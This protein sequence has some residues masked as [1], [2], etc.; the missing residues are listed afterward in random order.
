MTQLDD[1]RS[2]RSRRPLLAA[3]RDLIV[4]AW[5]PAPIALPVVD[6]ELTTLPAL[7]R[8][9]EVCRYSVLRLEHALS[10]GGRLRAWVRLH[11]SVAAILA[12]P[13]LSVVPVLTLL[14]GQ[15]V[16]LTAFLYQ[17]A[18]NILWTVLTIIATISA[19]LM[20]VYLLKAHLEGGRR[21]RR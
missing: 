5:E 19:A 8:V 15:F 7:E 20:F 2:A 10:R 3:A 4:N 16:T 21:G 9:T 12:I 6:A 1:A 11:L 13:A 18:M 14:L 17:A